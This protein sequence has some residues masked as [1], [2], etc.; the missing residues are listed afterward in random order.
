MTDTGVDTNRGG[1][2]LWMKLLLLGSLMINVAV[3]GIYAGHQMQDNKGY[4]AGSGNRQVEWILKLVPDERRD[5][6][7]EH[8]GDVRAQLRSLRQARR[9]KL[10]DIVVAVRTEPFVPDTLMKVL[11]E[12][13]AAGS[14]TRT[15][16]HERLVLLMAEF[17]PEERAT[18][19]NRL[20]ERIEQLRKRKGN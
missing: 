13:R 5:F 19:A 15:I 2:P 20:E 18:F 10:N 11:T 14:E 7:K 4:G 12:R 8:F 17:T 3:I 9:S 6:T 16:V 1:S